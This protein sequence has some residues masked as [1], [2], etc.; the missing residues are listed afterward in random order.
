MI[1][2]RRQVLAAVVIAFSAIAVTGAQQRPQATVTA[3]VPTRDIVAGRDAQLDLKVTL[4]PQ[5]HVQGNK[6][7]DPFLIPT[8]LTIDA[9][10]GVVVQ[11]I[12]YPKS[13]LLKQ[14][15][16]AEPLVVFGNEFSLRVR[17]KLAADLATG[18]LAIPGRLRYQACDDRRCY[19]PA[20][21]EATWTLRVA[22][23]R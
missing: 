6:P 12:V 14:A 3:S 10:K 8:V 1:R 13:E 20:R 18:A 11:E 19:P 5:I 21:A 2:V 23:A 4:P 22:A 7:K 17:V 9:P 15:G 16:V